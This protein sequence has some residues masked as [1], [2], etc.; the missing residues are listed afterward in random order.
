MCPHCPETN[1]SDI[2]NDEIIIG[3]DEIIIERWQD[4][5]TDA[6][7]G[8]KQSVLSPRKSIEQKAVKPTQHKIK[9]PK[10]NFRPVEETTGW[11][12]IRFSVSL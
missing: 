4:K 1:S 11:Y 6:Q 9:G 8:E 5:A 3:N 7:Q 12:A 10:I 2:G